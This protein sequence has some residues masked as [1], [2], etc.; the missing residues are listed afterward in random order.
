MEVVLKQFFHIL[1]PFVVIL[2]VLVI[3]F[4]EKVDKIANKR[5]NGNTTKSFVR[6]ETNIMVLHNQLV[7]IKTL[8]G[9]LCVLIGVLLF[10]SI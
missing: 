8:L 4:Y 6:L 7:K 10:F 2:G 1:S 3:F 5:I 9:I